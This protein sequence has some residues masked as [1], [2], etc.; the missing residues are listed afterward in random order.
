M[1]QDDIT[2]WQAQARKRREDFDAKMAAEEEAERK[3][4]QIADARLKQAGDVSTSSPQC[5]LSYNLTYT[6]KM[7]CCGCTVKSAN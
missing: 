6:V 5:A 3:D 2:S 1:A 7:Y 4:R